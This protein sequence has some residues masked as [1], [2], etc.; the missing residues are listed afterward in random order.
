M[1][2]QE[3]QFDKRNLVVKENCPERNLIITAQHNWV[4]L[5]T[6]ATVFERG[7]GGGVNKVVSQQSSSLGLAYD[8][9][10]SDTIVPGVLTVYLRFARRIEI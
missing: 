7:G 10:F 8:D 6:V 5:Y 9:V 4:I 1:K 2:V 3:V